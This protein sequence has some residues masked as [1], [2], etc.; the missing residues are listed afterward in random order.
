MGEQK[1]EVPSIPPLTQTNRS[2]VVNL[3]ATPM[4]SQKWCVTV[5]SR[6]ECRDKE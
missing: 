1:K 2:T 3:L 4:S 5:R 6:V